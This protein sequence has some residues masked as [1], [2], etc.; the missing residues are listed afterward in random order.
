MHY[1]F[2]AKPAA[3]TSPVAFAV[4][5]DLFFTLALNADG[6]LYGWGNNAAS[7]LAFPVNLGIASI[8]AGSVH[9]AAIKTNGDIV[10]WG[11]NT[12]GQGRTPAGFPKVF[13]VAAGERHTVALTRAPVMLP[14]NIPATYYAGST[15][16]IE[17]PVLVAD[18]YEAEWRRNGVLLADQTTRVLRITNFQSAAVYT[19]SVSNA[20][21]AVKGQ[22]LSLSVF[23]SPLVWQVQPVATAAA[24]GEGAEFVVW[25]QGSTATYEWYRNGSPIPNSNTNRL[26]LENVTAA[27]E[28]A[29]WAVATNSLSSITSNPAFLTTSGTKIDVEPSDQRA[30]AGW[31][32]NLKAHAVSV[33]PMEL[34]WFH[35]GVELT[36]ETNFTLTIPNV[37]AATAGGYRLRL[38]S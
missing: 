31:T 14:F 38:E 9:A 18:A 6:R 21:G 32:L 11:D 7:Q 28:G 17:F 27:D 36:G 30:R 8:A 5:R 22:D 33:F 13:R 26:V 4:G 37:S 19:L 20:Y 2:A 1:N 10:T 12:W 23:P 3:L 25:A 16:E 34:Q 24:P 29:Y 15:V 35:E